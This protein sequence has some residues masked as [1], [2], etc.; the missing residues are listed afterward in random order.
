MPLGRRVLKIVVAAFAVIVAL[1]NFGFNVNGIAAGLGIGGLAVALAAQKTVENLFGGVSLIADQPVRVGD[2]CRFG[3]TEGIVEDIGLRSTR[4]RTLDRTIV[5]IPNAQ[6][7]AMPLENLSRRDR[8]PVR[9]TLVLKQA[10]GAAHVRGVLE[11][12]RTML[13]AQPKV[14]PTSAAVRLAR[15]TPEAVE[16]EIVAYVLTSQFVSMSSGASRSCWARSMRWRR[17]FPPT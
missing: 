9:S 13:A 2:F 16:I 14:E 5:T 12:L 8:I 10:T 17:R 6:F 3:D 4:V 11:R 7:S 1:Q 15:I